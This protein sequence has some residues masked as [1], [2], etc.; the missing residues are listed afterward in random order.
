MAEGAPPRDNLHPL[1]V[2]FVI[3]IKP[4]PTL[5]DPDQ[6]S[7]EML[8]FVRCCCQKDPSQRHDS[9]QLSGHPFVKQEVIA[10]RAMYQNNIDNDINDAFTKYRK[11][12]DKAKKNMPGLLAI[13]RVM[14]HLV[15]R[16]QAVQEK[17]GNSSQHIPWTIGL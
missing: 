15:P 10:L 2:I 9:A 14:D 1:R 4:A 8:D 17:N 11:Q 6:W 7:P 5:A 12:A 13:R 3:P 16:M